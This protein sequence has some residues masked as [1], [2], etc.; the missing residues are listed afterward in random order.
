[1]TDIQKN[2]HSL[3]IIAVNKLEES[4]YKRG[5]RYNGV[6]FWPNTRYT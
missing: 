4:R 1:M 6:K 2:C 3:G 5:K